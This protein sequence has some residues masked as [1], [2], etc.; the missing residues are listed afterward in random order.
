MILGLTKHN[1]GLPVAAEEVKQCQINMLS[2]LAD[3]CDENKLRYYLDGGTLLGAVRH[4]GFIPWDDDIDIMIPH[5]D[6]IRLQE[7]SHGRIG[8]YLIHPPEI[9]GS[10]FVENWKMYDPDY[11]I[12]SDLGGTSSK[13]YYFP[14]FLDIFPME[15]LPD[16]ASET[17]A[18][19]RRTVF[20]RKL[21]H[22]QLGSVWHGKTLP[23]KLFHGVMR[24]IVK[25]IGGKKIFSLLQAS[26][27]RLSFNQASYV[28]NM[29]GP[30]HTTDS[31]VVKDDYIA[32]MSLPFEGRLYRVP[33]NYKQYLTQLYGKDC[34]TTL[35]PPEKQKTHHSFRVF[36]YQDCQEGLSE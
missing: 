21:L 18:W 15:G 8:R 29:S 13:K 2:A 26:K 30:V 23:R 11:V 17:A 5:P 9:S 14:V 20:Y 31:R 35:P 12:E 33:G 4:R 27:E 3:F 22:C 32:E 7:I 24:P 16:T 25:L 19:Y 28:G 1:C 10:Y 34:M 36:H 6:C